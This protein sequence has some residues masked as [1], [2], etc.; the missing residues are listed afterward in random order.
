MQAIG[1]LLEASIQPCRAAALGHSYS[2]MPGLFYDQTI[3]GL[4]QLCRLLHAHYCMLT[5]MMHLVHPHP[6]QISRARAIR[7]DEFLG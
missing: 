6:I 3:N 7:I 4:A 1:A 5:P 2:C